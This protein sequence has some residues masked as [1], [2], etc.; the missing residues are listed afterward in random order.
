MFS[1]GKAV[2]SHNR[3]WVSPM[4]DINDE[5]KS[6]LALAVQSLDAPQLQ[7]TSILRPT[8]FSEYGLLLVFIFVIIFAVAIVTLIAIYSGSD[9]KIAA[10]ASLIT[11]LVSGLIEVLFVFISNKSKKGLNE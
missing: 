5:R 3:T 9:L 8:T 6:R 2:L 10:L 7:P 1:F 11:G 4:K